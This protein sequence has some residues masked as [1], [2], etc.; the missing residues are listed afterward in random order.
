M[1]AESV[2]G[3]QRARELFPTPEQQRV[4]RD[5]AWAAGHSPSPLPAE[6]S[7]TGYETAGT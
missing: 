6:T 4:E 2:G 7:Q 5:L 1:A 3:T